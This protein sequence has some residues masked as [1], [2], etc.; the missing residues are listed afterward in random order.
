MVCLGNEQRSFCHFWDCIQVLHFRLFCCLWGLLFSSKG[1]LPRVVDIMVILIYSA[2]PIHFSSLIPKMSAFTRH[3][4]LH[5]IQFTFIYEPNKPGSNAIFFFRASEFTFTTRHIQCWVSFPFWP[6]LFILSGAISPISSPAAL[7]VYWLGARLP[8]SYIFAFISVYG[9]LRSI[10]LQWFAFP[11][12]NVILVSGVQHNDSR[13]IHMCTYNT[14]FPLWLSG[15]ES[16]CQH[17]RC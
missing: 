10:I 17:R 6:R 16:A 2:I 12:Y 11:F 5:H 3:L 9:A 13:Y 15:K 4:L 14:E 7:D 1:F 8:V